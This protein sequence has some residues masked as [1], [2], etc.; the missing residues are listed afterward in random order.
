MNTMDDN[1]YYG[2]FEIY[3]GNKVRDMIS[4][5]QDIDN[6]VYGHENKRFIIR[7]KKEHEI[8]ATGRKDDGHEDEED[9]VGEE[10]KEFDVHHVYKD[11][12]KYDIT[13]SQNMYE[14]ERKKYQEKYIERYSIPI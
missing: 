4:G 8:K 14:K 1:K 7:G 11:T 12:H 2:N 10:G 3:G 6:H 9:E 5:I 13:P